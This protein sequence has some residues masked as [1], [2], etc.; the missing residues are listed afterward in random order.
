MPE[1]LKEEIFSYNDYQ[2]NNDNAV[3]SIINQKLAPGKIQNF[4]SSYHIL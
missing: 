3:W 2:T 1:L 4:L